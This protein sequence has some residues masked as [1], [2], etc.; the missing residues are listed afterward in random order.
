M[1]DSFNENAARGQG[2]AAV[3]AAVADCSGC[4]ALGNEMNEMKTV[5]GPIYNL[6]LPQ[7][8]VAL[9]LLTK[10]IEEKD[11]E[12]ARAETEEWR[13]KQVLDMIGRIR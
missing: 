3:V 1:N 8:E 6:T 11:Q 4:P 12:I 5:R 9:A 2:R 13:V 7:A 10:I